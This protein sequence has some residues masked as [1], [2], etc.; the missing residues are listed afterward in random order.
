M[1][2]LACHRCVHARRAHARRAHAQRA[3]V[4]CAHTRRIH[5]RYAHNRY[6]YA[7]RAQGNGPFLITSYMQSP[8]S[9]DKVV[10][11]NISMGTSY[12]NM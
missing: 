9:C 6:A 10:R 5:A 1:S 2:N 12:Y 11:V 4:Q 8:I 3:H 7:Q